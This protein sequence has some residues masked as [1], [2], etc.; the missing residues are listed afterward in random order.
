[1]NKV[2]SLSLK[3]LVCAMIATAPTALLIEGFSV[4]T[5]QAQASSL[6]SLTAEPSV[7]SSTAAAVLLD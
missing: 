1:V 4:T 7:D 6:R 2:M 3:V 5:A